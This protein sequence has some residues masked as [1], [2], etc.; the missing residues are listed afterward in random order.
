MHRN[1]MLLPNAVGI[2][3]F[4]M[5]LVAIASAWALFKSL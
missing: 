4:L 3:L 2:F 5:F 1:N